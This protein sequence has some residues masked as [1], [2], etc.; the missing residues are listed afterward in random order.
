MFPRKIL[1]LFLLFPILVCSVTRVGSAGETSAHSAAE[2][3]SNSPILL[4][5][6]QVA[7]NSTYVIQNGN[8]L[9]N[10]TI[11]VKENATLIISNAVVDFNMSSSTVI[12]CYDNATVNVSNST[13]SHVDGYFY[14]YFNGKT[15]ATITDSLFVG[16]SYFYFY[17]T[18]TTFFGNSR[19]YEFYARTNAT[20]AMTDAS[21]YYVYCYNF[22]RLSMTHCVV[23]F[24]YFYDSSSVFVADS[25]ISDKVAMG[26]SQ[27][28]SLSLNLPGGKVEDWN[29]YADNSVAKAYVNLTLMHTRVSSWDVYCYDT[30]LVS[31]EDSSLNDL[32]AY[33]NS[34]ASVDNCTLSSVDAENYCN[35]KLIDSAVTGNLGMVFLDGSNLALTLPQGHFDNWN[36]YSDNTVFTAYLNLT[37]QDS[38]VTSWYVEAYN[39]KVSLSNSC[40]SYMYVYDNSTIS[41][42][43]TTVTDIHCYAFSSTTLASCTLNYAETYDYSELS[44]ADSV[45]SEVETYDNSSVSLTRAQVDDLYVNGYSSALLSDSLVD[46]SVSLSFV[47]GSN[48]SLDSLP[49]G[50]VQYWNLYQNGT[51]TVAHLNLTMMDTD[52]R[53]WSEFD[54]YDNSVVSMS[55]SIIEYVYLYDM[56]MF[57]IVNSM[58]DYAYI[59]A[60][61]SLSAVHSTIEEVQ[62]NFVSDS[63]VSLSS[64]PTGLVDFWNLYQNASVLRAY[65]NFTASHSWVLQWSFN[66][67]DSATLSLTLCSFDYA[68]AYDSSVFSTNNCTLNY[69][70]AYDRSTATLYRATVRYG[71]YLYDHATLTLTDSALQSRLYVEF[72]AD[73]DVSNLSPPIGLV[74]SW[75]LRGDAT[76]KRAFL[77][78]T[79]SNTTIEGWGFYV[80]GFS[81]VSFVNAYVEYLVT[82]D[83]SRVS[84]ENCTLEYAYV[85]RLS[86]LQMTNVPLG[87][88]AITYL[89]AYGMVTVT[90]NDSRVAIA[91]AHQDSTVELAASDYGAA[92][93]YDRAGVEVSY[94]LSVHI[95]DQTGADIAGANVTVTD[96]NGKLVDS[97]MTDSSGLTEFLLAAETMD[98]MG[99]HA[100]GS[101]NVTASHNGQTKSEA[102]TLTGNQQVLVSLPSTIPELTPVFIALFFL[103]SLVTFTVAFRKFKLP[104]RT[105]ERM[106]TA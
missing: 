70:G 38:N 71:L 104:K 34:S 64:L 7:G 28:S 60:D 4:S 16:D 83:L 10:D 41:A 94:F 90:L 18:S 3:F 80:Y 84:M 81:T 22:V 48:L 58:V 47:D 88:S 85:Y 79:I 45:F 91:Y 46:S 24:L 11:L 15:S 101:Y 56:S 97:S 9:L 19:A 95:V 26:L 2:S 77:N 49:T 59:M 75:S 23:C 87:H 103:A 63:S 76:V 86:Q 13:I 21:V 72:R 57:T 36:L 50:E 42:T 100:S 68:Y 54:L 55:N 32:S 82:Y 52:V 20:I 53:G 69:F 96:Q 89:Y 98:A 106:L 78:L 93:A 43:N 37:L 27:N 1:V 105:Q 40:L 35:V 73:S 12:Q 67:Y 62:L 66:T 51:V 39:S 65:L 25:F 17:D 44:A 30:S 8:Y 74:S 5:S 33:Q 102:L 6:V 31:I 14:V 61:S 29:L 92:Q 99:S